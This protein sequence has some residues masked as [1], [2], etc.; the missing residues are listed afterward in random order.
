MKVDLE[1]MS[2]GQVNPTKSSGGKSS[3]S[4]NKTLKNSLSLGFDPGFTKAL[5][6]ESF[7]TNLMNRKGVKNS[8][9]QQPAKNNKKKAK[10][11]KKKK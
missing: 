8:K 1:S 3:K 6:K 4:K 7:R 9:N 2:R 5:L 11:N 10:N